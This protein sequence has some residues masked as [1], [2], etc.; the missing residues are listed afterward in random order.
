M[1]RKKTSQ[2]QTRTEWKPAKVA[3]TIIGQSEKYG[4]KW[5]HSIG[6]WACLPRISKLTYV[7]YMHYVD[8]TLVCAREREGDKGECARDKYGTTAPQYRLLYAS[9]L[10]EWSIMQNLV[11]IECCIMCMEY[12]VCV[13]ASTTST[14][15]IIRGWFLYRARRKCLFVDDNDEISFAFSFLFGLVFIC[16]NTFT[17]LGR[18]LPQTTKYFHI[19]YNSKIDS[20][21]FLFFLSFSMFHIN[22]TYFPSKYMK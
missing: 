3:D 8:S 7:R 9:A 16:P 6:R 5:R 20:Q 10:G 13:F 2:Q 4:R 21:H 19:M 17:S 11:P 12:L 22:C 15:W 18:L 14:E 1:T